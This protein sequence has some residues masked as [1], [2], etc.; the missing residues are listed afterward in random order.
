M[1]AYLRNCL[2]RELEAWPELARIDAAC[3]RHG[4]GAQVTFT[5]EIR[6]RATLAVHGSAPTV[7]SA[8]DAATADLERVLERLRAHGAA[9]HA[10]SKRA[11]G[12]S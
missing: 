10:R 8:C 5:A 2:Q 3:A 4:D 12:A 9:P 6:G 1:Q 11:R 7:A